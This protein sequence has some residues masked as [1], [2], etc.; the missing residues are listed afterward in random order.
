VTGNISFDERGDVRGGAITM[1][2]VTNGKW[3]VLETVMGDNEQKPA[4]KK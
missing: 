3:E 1:Y 2:R 4:E